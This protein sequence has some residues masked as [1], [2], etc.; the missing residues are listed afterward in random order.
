MTYG[1]LYVCACVSMCVCLYVCARARVG[2]AV[3]GVN[4]ENRRLLAVDCRVSV[5]HVRVECFTPVGLGA[6]FHWTVEV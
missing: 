6:G 1:A 4:S 5:A 2:A 3:E